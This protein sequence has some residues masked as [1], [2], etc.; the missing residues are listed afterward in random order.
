MV[1]DLRDALRMLR[2]DP[3]FA[4]VAI[5]S[6]ALGI[7]ANT[8]IFSMADLLLFP[9]LGV[10]NPSGVIAVQSEFRRTNSKPAEI[11]R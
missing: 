9:R 5:V 3:R 11:E 8:A 7:G 4:L 6:L 10:P 2:H 1:H